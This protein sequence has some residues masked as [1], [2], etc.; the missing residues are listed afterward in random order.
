MDLSSLNKEQKEAVLSDKKS[1]LILAGA[2]SGKTRV[3]TSKIAYLIQEKGV[4]PWQVL[5]FTFTNKAANE[6]KER[7]GRA[8]GRPVD[9]MWIGTFHSICSRLLRREIHRLGYT[10]SYTIYDG[11]DQKTLVKKIMKELTISNKDLHPS[12]VI[13]QISKAKNLGWSPKT[14][15]EE[16]NNP[17]TNQ[18]ASIFRSYEKNLKAANALDFDDLILK[19]TYL[20]EEYP[21]VRDKYQSQFQYIFVDEYQ[22][23][24]H[25]QYRLILSFVSPTSQLT[26]VGDGD[27][28]I[29]GW[30][31]ADISNIL[32]FE[33]DFK[34]SQMI[35]LEQ[36]YRSSKKILEAANQLIQ[37]NNE[38]KKKNLWTENQTGK[39]VVFR[40]Y[41]S[42]INE[43][44]GVV[45]DIEAKHR[46]GHP[47]KD[48]AVLYRMN[49]QSRP[50]EEALVRSAIPY[51]VV[52][53]L[54][55]YD[56]KEI[57]D[58]VA[59]LQ[60]LVNPADDVS[61]RR[62]VNTP[63]RGIGEV[64]QEKLAKAARDHGLSMMDALLDEE[65]FEDLTP[66]LQTK[67]KPFRDLMVQLHDHLDLPLPDL[68]REV[69]EKSGYK[70]M[71]NRSQALEDETRIENI[72]AFMDAVIQY[73]EEEEGAN[74]VDYLQTLSLMSDLDK[75]EEAEDGVQ[76]MTMHSAKGLEFPIVYVVGMEEGLF[77]SQRSIDEGGLEEERRLMYV[78]MTRA[79]E[80]LYL[81]QAKSRMLYGSIKAS[82]RS[83]F[84]DEIEDQLDIE[85]IDDSGEK[86]FPSFVGARSGASQRSKGFRRNRYDQN[87]ARIKKLV[88]DR[89]AREATDLKTN[90]RV[91]DKVKHRRF[92]QGT[93]V[94]V[95]PR[96]NGDELTVAFDQKGLK[97]L[98]ASLA[99]LKKLT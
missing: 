35:L 46:E 5:A 12:Y 98:N 96:E 95:K 82:L 90:F 66:G 65:V 36:N 62:I 23:T 26:V 83:R 59:Y 49:V 18:I 69:Y 71:L 40:P 45:A 89:K 94:S 74:L 43:A 27:Q 80:E 53:G 86:E 51:K 37:N 57:K 60:V 42:D 34:D 68:V 25:A 81:S 39:P 92:G 38:R 72:S 88:Q 4:A 11:G 15:K 2:G 76:L 50:I 63:K 99:P 56:R 48:M 52:G 61:F 22:D 29:Y 1:L 28:S 31:G 24:N 85:A 33:K 87:R 78:A 8:L 20:M 6:M 64:S 14:Y 47:Y 16:T 7:V 10:S 73:D 9:S 30:R 79:E 58:L 75:T 77:P 84:I 19:M 55:F 32:N 13:D 21:E 93:V 67:F 41:S 3:L 17:F 44:S 54:K 91:G 70:A 97:R